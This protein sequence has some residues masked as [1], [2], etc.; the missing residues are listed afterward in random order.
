MF[1]SH[2]DAAPTSVT[3]GDVTTHIR[4]DLIGRSGA[5]ASHQNV[6]NKSSAFSLS[7]RGAASSAAQSD[8]LRKLEDADPEDATSLLSSPTPGA[9]LPGLTPEQ[10]R[11]VK[12][13]QSRA[14]SNP[15][16]KRSY[17]PG[18]PR[19]PE[20]ILKKKRDEEKKIEQER[21]AAAKE[22]QK[23]A[24]TKSREKRKIDV[25]RNDI[26]DEKYD[27]TY[28]E[29]VGTLSKHHDEILRIEERDRV[30]ENRM[31][32]AGYLSIIRLF[33]LWVVH[34]LLTQIPTL[35]T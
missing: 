34:K 32:K 30:K 4:S 2:P 17:R 29:L 18:D 3:V 28:D 31:E 14:I 20:M 15:N 9:A 16:V 27:G 11:S 8:Q 12:K 33:T 6:D 5:V 35:Q 24:R 26:A 19:S 21:L 13:N 23:L 7:S 10:L 22:K 1:G 25:I